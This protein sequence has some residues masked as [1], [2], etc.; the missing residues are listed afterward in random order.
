MVNPSKKLKQENTILYKDDNQTKRDDDD[1][2]EEYGRLVYNSDLV[3]SD[4]EVKIM[5]VTVEIPE[6]YTNAAKEHIFNM[7]TN[8]GAI[9]IH[10]LNLSD[11]RNHFSNVKA[12]CTEKTPIVFTVPEIVEVSFISPEIKDFTSLDNE[13]RDLKYLEGYDLIPKLKYSEAVNL[14]ANLGKFIDIQYLFEL[15][16]S[17]QEL[18]DLFIQTILEQLILF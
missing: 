14:L 5:R 3:H 1:G 2:D 10:G 12:A 18:L 7:L 13:K 16:K 6:T 15:E 8:H 17:L 9:D 11:V 4:K